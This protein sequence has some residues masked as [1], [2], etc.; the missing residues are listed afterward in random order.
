MIDRPEKARRFLGMRTPH[1]PILLY[2][3][4]DAGSAKAVE[5]AGAK[6]IATSNN[7]RAGSSCLV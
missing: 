3:I 1:D 7:A 2:N 5:D 6:A 4:W